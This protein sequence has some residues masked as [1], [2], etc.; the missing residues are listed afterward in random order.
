ME[1]P[2]KGYAWKVENPFEEAV[3]GQLGPVDIVEKN[4]LWIVLQSLPEKTTQGHARRGF[5]SNG[6]P[7]R[8]LTQEGMQIVPE[9]NI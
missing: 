2:I 4:D 9:G 1:P 7:V 5:G 3:K 6:W 8:H